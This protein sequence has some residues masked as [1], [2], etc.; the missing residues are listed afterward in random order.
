MAC[1]LATCV[2]DDDTEYVVV[3][4][5]VNNVQNPDGL[6]E[7]GLLTGA[8][9]ATA[10]GVRN[11][12]RASSVYSL[13]NGELRAVA[14]ARTQ[15]LGYAVAPFNGMLLASCNADVRALREFFLCCR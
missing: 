13:D 14:S 11:R 12:S 5:A 1:G 6:P 15:G 8:R 4:T 2:F 9:N 3:S 7:D 10:A